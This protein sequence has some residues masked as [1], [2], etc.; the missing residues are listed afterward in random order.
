MIISFEC[1]KGTIIVNFYNQ[2]IFFIILDPFTSSFLKPIFYTLAKVDFLPFAIGHALQFMAIFNPYFSQQKED[3]IIYIA[4][5]HVTKTFSYQMSKKKL[6]YQFCQVKK[7]GLWD[8]QNCSILHT[9][10]Q[11]ILNSICKM[12]HETLGLWPR[13]CL[14]PD[15]CNIMLLLIAV[16]ASSK[17]SQL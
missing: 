3:K 9:N 5:V 14:A 13:G 4:R 15:F 7:N 1:L 8:D 16:K 11:I 17:A 12:Q 6:P 2:I 10:L